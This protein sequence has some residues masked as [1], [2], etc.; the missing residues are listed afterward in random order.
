MMTYKEA[1]D[2]IHSVNWRGSRPGLSRIT[3]LLE[4]I[5]NPEKALRCIHIAGTNGKGST[6]A[7]LTSVLTEAGYRVGL[8]TSPFIERFNERIMI[9]KEPISDD[10]LCELLSRVAPI[11]EAMDDKPT[12]FELITALGFLY[13]K[14]QAVDLVVLEVGMGGRLDSTNVIEAPLLSIITGIALDHMAVLGDTL[15]KIAA[16]KAGIIKERCPVLYGGEE[17]SVRTVIEQRAKEKK[18]PFYTTDRSTLFVKKSD[19][20]GSV[21]DYQDLR[22]LSISLSGLYQT[23]NAA[24][25]LTAVALL[26]KEGLAI[27]DRAIRTGLLKTRWRARFEVLSKEPLFVFDGSHNPQG[28]TAA[29]E[30]IGRYFDKKVLLLTGV[31]A[32][33]DYRDMA[34]T[35]FPYVEQVFCITPNNPRAL[36]S[37]ALAAVYREVGLSAEAFDDVKAGV[38]AAFLAARA[39]G[40]AVVALGSLYMYGEVKAALFENLK[41]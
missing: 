20:F 38:T 23:R 17:N 22:E 3:A 37:K 35:L 36:S 33:K 13:F 29:A 9:G 26:E 6:S 40:S 39:E 16:E 8:F 25:V 1:L 12:E 32:D 7:M 5:G 28:V 21:F 18:A 4:K 34:K 11:A 31:M 30:S 41:K 15:E 27:S 24:T 10:D 2:Y 19:L 14:E